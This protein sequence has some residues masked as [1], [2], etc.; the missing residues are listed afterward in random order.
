MGGQEH[1][2]FEPHSSLVQPSD[3][4]FIVY[5]STQNANKTQ[6]RNANENAKRT[7]KNGK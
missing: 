4:D 5:T 7:E 2:Y 3:G 6:V 1:F